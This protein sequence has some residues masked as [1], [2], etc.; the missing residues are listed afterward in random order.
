MVLDI[1]FNFNSPRRPDNPAD[2][3]V[4]TGAPRAG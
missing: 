1:T 4:R 2:G 3:V